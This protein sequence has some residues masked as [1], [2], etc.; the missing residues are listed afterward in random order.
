MPVT[1]PHMPARIAALPRDE[2]GYPVPRFIE[3]MKAGKNGPEKTLRPPPGMDPLPGSYPDFRYADADFRALAFRTGLCW[4]CGERLGL[5]RVYVL[6][7]MCVIN[8]VTSEP[9]CHRDC[10]EFSARACP[11]LVRPRMR[12]IPLAEDEPRVVAGNMIDRNP[13]CTALYETPRA[14]AFRAEGGWLIRVDKPDRVDWWA[15][16]RQ[17][18]LA[19]IMASIDS[20][21][22]LLM[23]MAR[24]E[25]AQAVKELEAL[26]QEAFRLLPAA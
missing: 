25:G 24:Q 1:L 23:D 13:G 22:P 19:E 8:R 15:E 4:V 2:R 11:F 14:T 12:R 16:G 5:H 17:A 9:A 21:Y 7:P 18:T 26:K 6:G 20:G 10:A 3:W